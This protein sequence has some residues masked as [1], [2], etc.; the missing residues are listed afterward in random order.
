MIFWSTGGRQLD[1]G[2]LEQR[3]CE[4]CGTR[5][6]FRLEVLYRTFSLYWIFKFVTSREYRSVCEV[7]HDGAVLDRKRVESALDR[8][9][10]PA[11]DRYG[12]LTLVGAVVVFVVAVGA[13]APP[14]AQRDDAGDI[15]TAG[16]VDVYEIAVGD[17]FNDDQEFFSDEVAE[18]N[19][20]AGVPCDEP[21]DNEVYA[22]VDLDLHTF[23]GDEQ[24]TTLAFDA[25][26]ARFD[27][28][29]GRDYQSS[30]YDVFPIYPTEASWNQDDDR[31]VICALYDVNLKPLVGTAR[32]SGR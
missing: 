7:C 14:S 11:T 20:V 3:H 22:T 31:E 32:K 26:V 27:A 19:A 30:M 10:I 9:P 16:R 2:A 13:T 18:F 25:C 23:P 6:G 8:S 12:L 1:L 24:M 5:R 21:H 28:F 17:C 15:A 29:V 4:T